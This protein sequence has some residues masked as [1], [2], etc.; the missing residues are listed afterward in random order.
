MIIY[1]F[2]TLNYLFHL[3][4]IFNANK[5]TSEEEDHISNETEPDDENYA[6]F[7]EEELEKLY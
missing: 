2:V 6:I 1:M 7:L 5:E 4:F 3:D